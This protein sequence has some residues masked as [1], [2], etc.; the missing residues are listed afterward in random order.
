MKAAARAFSVFGCT[1]AMMS[2]SA[3]EKYPTGT[4]DERLVVITILYPLLI[5]QK[6]NIS[7]TNNLWQGKKKDSTLTN[8]QKT[9]RNVV[10]EGS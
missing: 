10:E 8:P 7:F 6:E 4:S 5:Q 1:G 9:A 2:Y 3:Q